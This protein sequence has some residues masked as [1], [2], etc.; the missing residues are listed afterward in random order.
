MAELRQLSL[1][2]AAK[3][4]HENN[5]KNKLTGWGIICKERQRKGISRKA[6]RLKKQ[7]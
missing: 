2:Q 7:Q 1:S 6:K 3:F 5:L 4:D